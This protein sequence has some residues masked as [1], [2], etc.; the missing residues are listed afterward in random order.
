MHRSIIRFFIGMALLAGCGHRGLSQPDGW[1]AFKSKNF[2][3]YSAS[4]DDDSKEA[5]EKLE[6]TR[7]A[8]S[9][10][11]FRNVDPGTIEVLLVEDTDKRE[12]MGEKRD[13]LVLS[14]LPD[15]GDIGKNGLIVVG[16]ARGGG[17]GNESYGEALAHVFIHKM[18]PNAP[19]WFH[20]GFSAYARTLTYAEADGKGIGC[21]GVKGSPPESFVPMNDLF[22]LSWEQYDDGPRT[23]YKHTA[24]SLVDY[25]LHAEDGQLSPKMAEI[26]GG[27]IEGKPSDQV[28]T[29][30]LGDP[31]QV[32]GKVLEHGKLT[33]GRGVCP[34]PFE[35]PAD[36]APDTSEPKREPV[37]PEAI[38]K[39]TT[40][41]AKIPRRE[42]YPEWY[43]PAVLGKSQ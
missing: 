19:L 33:A 4:A 8:L 34:L 28:V 20:E 41:L 24:R 14:T 15:G 30:A 17:G 25:V 18:L 26:L 1:S 13:S 6:Q 21:F 42:G 38:S 31:Q 43:P 23:W 3:M 39:L 5:I 40:A 11:F 32:Y 2:T 9:A 29:A 7:A 37:A 27:L 10:S 36:K 22:T 12:V 35:I 16:F